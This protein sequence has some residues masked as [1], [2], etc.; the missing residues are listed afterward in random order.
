M[1]K[2]ILIYNKESKVERDSFERI[3]QEMG[4]YII[5]EYDFQDVRNIYPVHSTP[6]LIPI[7][8]HLCGDHLLQGDTQLNF[9]AEA[10]RLIAEEE[11]KIHQAE[12]YRLDNLINSEK[13]KSEDAFLNDILERGVI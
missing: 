8:D 7:L 3:R 2:F 4:T 12:T 10:N 11:L 5:A 1:A 13:S 6:A 9:T